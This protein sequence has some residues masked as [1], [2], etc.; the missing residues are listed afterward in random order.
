MYCLFVC[1]QVQTGGLHSLNGTVPNIM[2]YKD[3]LKPL[4]DQVD[5]LEIFLNRVK[6][7][8]DVVES[9]VVAAEADLGSTDGK[10]KNIFKPLFFVSLNTRQ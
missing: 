5:G 4:C 6:H 2:L 8:L 9:H 7:D 3:R 1:L 10:L